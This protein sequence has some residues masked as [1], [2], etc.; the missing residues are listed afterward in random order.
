[1]TVTINE[2]IQIWKEFGPFDLSHDVAP[3]SFD[4]RRFMARVG[5]NKERICI[6]GQ[7]FDVLSI[8]DLV[9]RRNA[10][11]Y[12]RAVYIQIN[13]RSGEYYIGKVN[14]PKWSELTR[15]KGSGLKFI[16][17][18]NKSSGEFVQYYIAACKTADETEQLE[19]S[20]VDDNLLADEMCLNLVAGGGGSSKH[21]TRAEAS[22]KKR[23][24]MKS[25]P[26][27]FAPML[28]ASKKAFRSGDT[29]ALRERSRRI[30]EVMS[31]DEY[32]RLS[33]ERIKKWR[34][35]NPL[36]YWAARRKN[37]EAIKTTECRD[38]RAASR[39]KWIREN[40][41]KH[42]VWEENRKAALKKKET[43]EKH[44]VSLKKWRETNPD[45]A[46]ANLVKRAKAAAEKLSK[47]VCMVDLNSGKVLMTFSSQHEAAR[48][49]VEKGIAKNTNCVSS[50]NSVCLRKPCST[51]YGYRK[52]AYGYDWRFAAEI[53]ASSD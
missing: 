32:R 46:K 10:D 2:N 15:Y 19:A 48:W 50:I 30:K 40:P 14:R 37:H 31:T 11:G 47:Q 27:R 28:E 41:E 12:Y 33:A 4:N 5:D 53:R 36:M 42:R 35:H 29:R 26:E 20:I 18:F 24:Y 39:E 23:E 1:M 45:Q 7:W 43:K 21:P 9:R 51:G 34:E 3:S 6:R 25:H 44:K 13:M 8:S 38:K 52:K 17:K 22:L 49:L 16:N